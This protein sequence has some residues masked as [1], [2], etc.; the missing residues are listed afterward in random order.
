MS[1][2]YTTGTDEREKAMNIEA[3]AELNE[4][5][6]RLADSGAVGG[7]MSVIAGFGSL[8]AY[9]QDWGSI[10]IVFN[11]D[12]DCEATVYA[13]LGQDNEHRFDSALKAIEWIEACN[14]AGVLS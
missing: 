11:V 4:L 13:G 14:A 6:G 9:F 5:M 10:D 7:R 2:V 8:T 1:S 12:G 3:F